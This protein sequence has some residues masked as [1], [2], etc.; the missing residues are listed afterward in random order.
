MR[1]VIDEWIPE[2]PL[3][4]N[5]PKPWACHEGWH[6]HVVTVEINEGQASVSLDRKICNLCSDGLADL[7]SEYLEGTFKANITGHVEHSLDDVWTWFELTPWPPHPDT[8][9]L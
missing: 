3:Y 5:P 2:D 6:S 7:E 8:P 4:L 1:F 9:E